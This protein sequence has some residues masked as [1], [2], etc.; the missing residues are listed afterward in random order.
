M[1][2]RI[3]YILLPLIISILMCSSLYAQENRKSVIIYKFINEKSA[4]NLNY[5]SEIIPD[6]ISLEIIENSNYTINILPMIN[7]VKNII[8]AP[9]DEAR[10]ALLPEFKADADFIIFGS[11]K[12]DEKSGK[13][14]IRSFSYSSRT[15]FLFQNDDIITDQG[16]LLI[17]N[18][19]PLSEACN[20][21]IIEDNAA[22]TKRMYNKGM[23]NFLKGSYFEFSY[24]MITFTGSQ[25]KGVDDD[26][27]STVSYFYSF[28]DA[29][30]YQEIPLINVSGIGIKYVYFDAE[31]SDSSPNVF[32]GYS[33]SILLNYYFFFRPA[34]FMNFS[35]YAGCGMTSMLNYDNPAANGT[36]NVKKDF[37]SVFAAGFDFRF[38]FNHMTLTAGAGLSN[39]F[40][41]EGSLSAFY[42]NTGAGIR[43]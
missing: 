33:R 25:G 1:K 26:Y 13:V 29:G 38:I 20:E 17:E 16:S 36:D 39:T 3:K 41:D 40:M 35:I 14:L 37:Y 9:D 2:L 42:I 19:K 30:I 43:F 28:Y 31:N 12:I 34:D 5:L 11:Y 23:Y 32:Y 24:G 18:L 27:M 22:G 21:F 7:D 15:G 8:I 4:E 6:Q 10:K